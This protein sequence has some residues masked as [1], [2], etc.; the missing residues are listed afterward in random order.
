M[1][2]AKIPALKGRAKIIPPLRG[3]V[4]DNEN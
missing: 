2:I 4:D 1:F 3:A